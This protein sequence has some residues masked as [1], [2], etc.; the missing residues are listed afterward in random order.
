MNNYPQQALKFAVD[1]VFPVRCIG[2]GAYDMYLCPSCLARVRIKNDSDM[3]GK[4]QVFSATDYGDGLIQKLLKIFKY[5]F[6]K[7]LA[8]PLSEIV[9]VYIDNLPGSLGLFAGNPILVPI[10]LHKRR[11]NWRGFNQSENLAQ[12][13]SG[14][15]GFELYPSVLTRTKNSKPQADIESR[16]DRLGNIAGIFKCEED[17]KGRNIILVDDICTTGATINECAK[18][19]AANGAG[20]IRALVVARG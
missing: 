12:K 6:V 9:R 8:G 16:D 2:C 15:Y 5:S 10:P 7:D 4:V 1:I 3:V 13:I 19:L 20:K 11:L 14:I 18:V 17:L